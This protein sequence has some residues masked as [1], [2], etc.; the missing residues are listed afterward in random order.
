MKLAVPKETEPG[1][2]RV[3]VVPETVKRVV[4]KGIEVSVE[5]GAGEGARFPDEEYKEAGATIEHSAQALLSAAD[6]IVKLHRPTAAEIAKIREGAALI[7]PLYPLLY[8]D[9]VTTLAAHK[10]T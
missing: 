5:S 2:A 6:V 7:S 1:E 10:I 3:A 8:P 9:L 4:K